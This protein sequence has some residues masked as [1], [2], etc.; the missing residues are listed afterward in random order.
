MVEK[1]HLAG[2][3]KTTFLRLPTRIHQ[4]PNISVLL[5]EKEEPVFFIFFNVNQSS[6][7]LPF[8]WNS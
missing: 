7:L 1:I 4:L 6:D 3:E 5:Y 8:S 2:I